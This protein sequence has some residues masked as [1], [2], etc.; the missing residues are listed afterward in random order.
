MSE[1]TKSVGFS[2][3]FRRTNAKM[4]FVTTEKQREGRISI[5]SMEYAT[6][7]STYTRVR[8]HS[9]GVFEQLSP[10]SPTY[11]HQRPTH[12]RSS[13]Q[14]AYKVPLHSNA[15]SVS[16]I[17]PSLKRKTSMALRK[18]SKP[19]GSGAPDQGGSVGELQSKTLSRPNTPDG[20]GVRKARIPFSFG[21]KVTIEE[22]KT[23]KSKVTGKTFVMVCTATDPSTYPKK[24]SK[25]VFRIGEGGSSYGRN[26]ARK[27]NVPKE[28]KRFEFTKGNSKKDRKAQPQREEEVASRD[29]S[30]SLPAVRISRPVVVRSYSDNST[31]SA[32]PGLVPSPTPSPLYSPVPS[33]YSTPLHSPLPSPLPSPCPSPIPSPIPFL[34]SSPLQPPP[35]PLSLTPGLPENLSARLHTP[36]PPP[37]SIKSSKSLSRTPSLPTL[38]HDSGKVAR[39]PLLNPVSVWHD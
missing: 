22:E 7:D 27:S 20:T 17:Q 25:M 11:S 1:G 23:A 31:S 2:S 18:L 24:A 36:L 28:K 21:R 37:V 19:G 6:V 13:S 30:L 15:P 26:I 9:T 10:T 4:V 35:S 5:T 14:P 38:F 39:Q 32:P 12:D 8:G 29:S 34:R 16:N 3:L 33:L